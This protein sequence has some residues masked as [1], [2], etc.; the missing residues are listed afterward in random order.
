MSFRN[1]KKEIQSFGDL[2]V[3]IDRLGIDILK[4]S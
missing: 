4:T 3:T 2:E 1:I